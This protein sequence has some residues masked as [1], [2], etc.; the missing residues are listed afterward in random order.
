MV[1]VVVVL[2]VVTLAVAVDEVCRIWLIRTLPVVVFWRW[3]PSPGVSSSTLATA[4][5]MVVMNFIPEFRQAGYQSPEA[6][7]AATPTDP[8]SGRRGEPPEEPMREATAGMHQEVWV[9]PEQSL[10]AYH[11]TSGAVCANR[12]EQMV[13][14]YDSFRTKWRA[15]EQLDTEIE[16]QPYIFTFN[17]YLGGGFKDSW[18]CT[19]ENLGKM[20]SNLSCAYFSNVLVKPPTR[21]SFSTSSFLSLIDHPSV[22]F[23]WFNSLWQEE[24][25]ELGILVRKPQLFDRNFPWISF[26]SGNRW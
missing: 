15:I 20:E 25:R 7:R 24:N 9:H 16:H 13:L 17:L 6:L 11:R 21:E 12:A 19:P 14:R 3:A 10:W 26:G 5:K 18:S 2:I 23:G 22:N 1:L 8:K 4:A